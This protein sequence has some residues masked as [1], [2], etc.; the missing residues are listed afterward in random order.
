MKHFLST[1]SVNCIIANTKI[2]LSRNIPSDITVSFYGN[3]IQQ[4]TC[5]LSSNAMFKQNFQVLGIL[6]F[7]IVSL[8]TRVFKYSLFYRKLIQFF[9]KWKQLL[10]EARKSLLVWRK[11]WLTFEFLPLVFVEK[12]ENCTALWLQAPHLESFHKAVMQAHSIPHI[13]LQTKDHL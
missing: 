2:L 9:F 1:H 5:I 11:S 12:S 6:V 4:L 10:F 3:T 7:W 8:Y 13:D